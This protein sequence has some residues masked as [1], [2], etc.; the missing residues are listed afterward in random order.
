MD[1]FLDSYVSLHNSFTDHMCIIM[2]ILEIGL[3]PKMHILN[4]TLN[5]VPSQLF[6]W[7]WNQ[8]FCCC[9]HGL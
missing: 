2:V 9:V 1:Q 3:D 4:A 5:L 7:V 8:L 6:P